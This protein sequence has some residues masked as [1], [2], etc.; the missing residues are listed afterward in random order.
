MAKPRVTADEQASAITSDIVFLPNRVVSPIFGDV[1]K[2]FLSTRNGKH[3]KS[4]TC[5]KTAK[6]G[7]LYLFYFGVPVS[8][9]VG[10]AV[11]KKEPDPEGWKEKRWGNKSKFFSCSWKELHH[12]SDPIPVDRI[13]NGASVLAQWWKTRP[14][15]GR[16]KT[17]PDPVAQRLLVEIASREVDARDVLFRYLREDMSREPIGSEVLND[18][19]WEGTRQEV[20]V[21]NR[22][23]SAAL[24]KRKLEQVMRRNNGDIV[25]EVPGCGF[26]FLQVYGEIGRGFA[27]VHHLSPIADREGVT[28]LSDL[29][30]VC[31]NCHAMIHHGAKIRNLDGLISAKS[32]RTAAQ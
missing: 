31:A 9:I 1:Y 23:R 13:S 12:F 5:K 10:M 20:L 16:P 28:K 14:F 29:A 17:I 4:W 21:R 24:R 25:C 11:C 3:L 7:D 2:K 22:K 30:V 8:A 19:A 26:S 27:H 15:Q 6:P 18:G 32:N